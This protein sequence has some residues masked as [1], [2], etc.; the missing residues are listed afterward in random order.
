MP[1]FYTEVDPRGYV[2]RSMFTT[3]PDVYSPMPGYRLLPDNPPNP[4]QYIAGE[5]HPVRI[6]PVP[7]DATEIPYEIVADDKSSYN[8][9]QTDLVDILSELDK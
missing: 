1:I 2:S 5:T 3:N 8:N 6:E 9:V 4:P 7:L